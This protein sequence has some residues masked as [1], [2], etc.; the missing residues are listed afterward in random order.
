MNN[1]RYLL[2]IKCVAFHMKLYFLRK[3]SVQSLVRVALGHT[4]HS[5]AFYT[6]CMHNFHMLCDLCHMFSELAHIRSGC[7]T[8]S[9]SF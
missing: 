6:I 4:V 7:R 3:R 2:E 9:C 5:H 8:A 1:N